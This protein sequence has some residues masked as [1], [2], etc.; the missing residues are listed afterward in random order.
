MPA[1]RPAYDDPG[2]VEALAGSQVRVEG[3]GDAVYVSGH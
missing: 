1:Q 2:S 3:L